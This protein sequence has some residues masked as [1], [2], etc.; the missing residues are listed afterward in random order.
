M[1]MEKVLTTLM[2]KIKFLL[3]K[4]KG[5]LSKENTLAC[6]GELHL[7]LNSPELVPFHDELPNLPIVHA[8]TTFKKKDAALRYMTALAD[9]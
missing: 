9:L 5:K 4:L 1:K 7:L 3:L 2:E 6:L 8:L